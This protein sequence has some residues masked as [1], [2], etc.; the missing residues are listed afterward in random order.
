MS[1]SASS[2][3]CRLSG[4]L[5]TCIILASLLTR[6]LPIT[7]ATSFL[8]FAVFIWYLVLLTHLPIHFDF[9]GVFF[10]KA[11]WSMQITPHQHSYHTACASCFLLILTPSL[12]Y[13]TFVGKLT[14]LYQLPSYHVGVG[15]QSTQFILSKWFLEVQGPRLVYKSNLIAETKWLMHCQCCAHVDFKALFIVDYSFCTR[16]CDPSFQLRNSFWFSS[17]K[18]DDALAWPM[19]LTGHF[20]N[21]NLLCTVCT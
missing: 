21:C 10:C 3:A 2:I 6:L 17:Y 13:L 1:L 16:G 20:T 12:L 9:L 7:I 8:V 14:L 11:S 18:S 4:F 19:V 15:V 5:P